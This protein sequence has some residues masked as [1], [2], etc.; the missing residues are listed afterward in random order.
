VNGADNAR[1]YG[2]A[3]SRPVAVLPSVIVPRTIRQEIESTLRACGSQR[4]ECVVYLAAPLQEPSAVAGT[5]RQIVGFFHPEHGNAPH[6]YAVPRT[7]VSAMSTALFEKR[8]Q[9]VAQIHTHPGD[10]FHSGRD[11]GGP[12]VHVPGFV[13]VVVP[14]FCKEGLAG[15]PGCYV[16]VYEGGGDWREL[17]CDEVLTTFQVG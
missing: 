15:L 4:W 14:S 6:Y 10:A 1:V 16:T 7:A 5:P 8:W 3:S 2:A 11:D 13:S 9:I 12:M 17:T